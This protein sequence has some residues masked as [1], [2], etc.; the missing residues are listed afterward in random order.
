MKFKKKTIQIILCTFVNRDEV[1][2][3]GDIILEDST[4][5]VLKELFQNMLVMGE[6]T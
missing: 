6:S 3:L 2:V 5:Y 1:P 4:F